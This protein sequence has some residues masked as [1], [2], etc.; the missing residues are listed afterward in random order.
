L[1]DHRQSLL[2]RLPSV[3]VVLKQPSCQQLQE[4]YGRP[5]VVSALRALF[6]DWRGRL[7]RGEWGEAELQ[8]ALPGLYGRLTVRLESSA[9]PS[10]HPVINATGVILHT[11]LGRSLLA[12]PAKQQMV[13][14]AS[15]YST[16]EM[17]VTTGERGSRYSHVHQLLLELTG[18]EDAIV[19]NNN[20]GA[21][22]LALAAL[23]S[24]R[25]VIV[26][27]G[28]LVEI[29]GSFR[30]PE[31]MEQS[32][33]RLVEVGT[34]N[35][36][37]RRDYA[38][39]I[40]ADTAALLKV[41]TSNYR[42]IGFSQTVSGQEMAE[43][44]HQHG[45][46]AI[47]DLGSGVLIDL[48]A[49]GYPH[50]P[51]VVESLQSGMDVVT[52]SGDKLL[53]G[54]QAGIVVGKSSAI[55]RMRQHPL[56]RALRID[57]LTLAA[58]EAT[59]RLYRDPQQAT[60]QIPTLRMLAVKEGTLRERAEKIAAGLT[61]QLAELADVTVVESWSQVGGGSLPG[62]DIP[63]VSLAVNPRKTSV[64]H[65]ENAL[66]LGEPAVF[67]RIQQQQLLLDLRTIQPEEDSLLQQALVQALGGAC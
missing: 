49:L 32:G 3:D 58:L 36:T 52:F 31:V 4:Q 46:W 35:K 2:R 47:E 67:C 43:L 53:G 8:A 57:K 22:L 10:L 62:H 16:L 30:I 50:E 19:V 7:Q 59:L 61:E 18:A 38:R 26:S 63:S 45:L 15:S 13:Q 12:E 14:V 1:I 44:A 42:I 55:S 29:G 33:C 20:A 17:D 24:G 34:T 25:Q 37:H 41:H 54:P 9:R 23:T 28:Q 48:A 64:D 11:N 66:R 56:N 6:D 60:L 21:V 65:L 51:T 39:A 27:R 40:T 5:A